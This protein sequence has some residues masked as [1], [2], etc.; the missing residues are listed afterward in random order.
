MGLPGRTSLAR[1]LLLAV[2][3]SGLALTP[4]A[5]SAGAVDS[6]GTPQPGSATLP[7]RG[8]RAAGAGSFAPGRVLVGFEAGVGERRRAAAAAAVDGR[9]VAGAGRERVV[10]LGPGAEVRA[11]ARRL[12]GEPGVAFAEPDWIRRVDACDPNVCWHLEPRPGANVVAAHT[13]D[14][15]GA[16]RTV[17]VVDTGVASNV[18]DLT[19]QVSARLRCTA[20][21]CAADAAPR[22]APTAPRW[23]A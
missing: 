20:S 7:V 10:A 2:A 13:G 22:P 15:R 16:G 6:P 14:H 4:R 11:A 5:A 8:P 19:G 18:A 3:L 1:I 21:G 9:V 12:A 17:A 23:P